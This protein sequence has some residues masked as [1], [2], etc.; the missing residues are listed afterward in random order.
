MC[1]SEEFKKFIE[2]FTDLINNINEKINRCTEDNAC[3]LKE[4]TQKFQQA[5][6]PTIFELFPTFPKLPKDAISGNT[7]EIIK[8]GKKVEI[9]QNAINS[10]DESNFKEK[11]MQA[12]EEIDAIDS[13][14][15]HTTHSRKIS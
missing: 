4:Y 2:K 7:N 3:I 13:Q 12:L 8:L 1:S 6:I 14:I 10:S 11:E 15:S 9:L 5:C